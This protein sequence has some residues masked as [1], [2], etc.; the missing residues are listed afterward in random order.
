MVCLFHGCDF[1]FESCF[2]L[3]LHVSTNFCRGLVRYCR[4]YVVGYINCE[5]GFGVRGFCVDVFAGVLVVG[6]VGWVLCVQV[7]FFILYDSAECASLVLFVIIIGNVT[8]ILRFSR[9]FP[10]NLNV[11]IQL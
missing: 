8:F 7:V 2:K 3:A 5:V 6:M 4:L 10:S 11:T 1:C 9:F